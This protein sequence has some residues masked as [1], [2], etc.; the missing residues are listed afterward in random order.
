VHRK[1]IP[2]CRSEQEARYAPNDYPSDRHAPALA[3]ARRNA[4]EPTRAPPRRPFPANHARPRNSRFAQGLAKEKLSLG[5]AHAPGKHRTPT[6]TTSPAL[7]HS[8][9]MR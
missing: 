9:K 4:A 7:I 3:A 1:D 8:E 2:E 6:P 5:F